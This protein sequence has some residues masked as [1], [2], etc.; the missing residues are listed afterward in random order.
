MY[1]IIICNIL[2]PVLISNVVRDGQIALEFCDKGS[3]GDMLRDHK[4]PIRGR[5]AAA[6]MLQLLV[7]LKQLHDRGV[8]HRDIKADNLL[9]MESGEVKLADMG[10]GR[11][12]G[13]GESKRHTMQLSG[14]PYWLPPDFLNTQDYSAKTDVWAVGVV[15]IELLE[16]FPPLHEFLPMVAMFHIASGGGA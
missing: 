5:H 2:V 10:L 1:S 13:E 12:L 15:L 4:T 11:V 3:V 16:V 9:L 8:V 14:S 6:V 7:S